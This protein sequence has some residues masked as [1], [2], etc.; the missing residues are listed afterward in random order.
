MLARGRARGRAAEYF[1]ASEVASDKW[2]IANGVYERATD[3]YK[4]QPAAFKAD[5]D[6]FAA[7]M[8]AY[9]KAHPDQLSPE[10]RAVRMKSDDRTSIIPARVRRMMEG[11][12]DSA[13][14]TTGRMK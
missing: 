8:N 6:A 13:S 3:W 14:V 10:A 4:Q 11:M 7:G 9:G 1:G 2:A 5:L 12:M